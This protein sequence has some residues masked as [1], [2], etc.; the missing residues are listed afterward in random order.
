MAVTTGRIITYSPDFPGRV[1]VYVEF[2]CTVI[3][4]FAG[5]EVEDGVDDLL[6]SV[7]QTTT[8]A[9]DVLTSLIWSPSYSRL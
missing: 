4:L 1:Q 3:Q 9:A 2:G 7:T 8:A 6:N 5:E